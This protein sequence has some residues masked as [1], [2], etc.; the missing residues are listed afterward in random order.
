[1]WILNIQN[2]QLGGWSLGSWILAMDL[3]ET[4]SHHWDAPKNDGQLHKTVWKSLI[5]INTPYNYNSLLTENEIR[6][7]YE[8]IIYV[9]NS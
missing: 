9:Y 5:Y 4:P 2:I 1:M 6:K 7:I 8:E 3:S